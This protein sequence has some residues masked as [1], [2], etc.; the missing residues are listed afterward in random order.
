MRAYPLTAYCKGG[1]HLHILNHA[2]TDDYIRENYDISL[3]EHLVDVG[4]GKTVSRYRLYTRKPMPLEDSLD[5]DIVCPH[6]GNNLRVCGESR[7]SHNH[8]LYKCPVCDSER[9]G[10]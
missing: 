5:Y 10:K 3:W 8:A 7:D 9:S 4:Y 6:C 1:K 2:V